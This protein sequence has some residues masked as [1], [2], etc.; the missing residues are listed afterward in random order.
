MEY[1]MSHIYKKDT[2]HDPICLQLKQAGCSVFDMSMIGNG[3]PDALVRYINKWAFFE[4]KSKYGKLTDAQIKW[5]KDNPQ[6]H[7]YLFQV[8]T[9]E[10]ACNILRIKI[11]Q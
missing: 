2:C 9:F 7:M 5:R 1:K 3:A 8:R 10:E 6:W 4:F 11:N